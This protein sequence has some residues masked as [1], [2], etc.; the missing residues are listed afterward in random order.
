[1]V[2]VGSKIAL[3]PCICCLGD[4]TGGNHVQQIFSLTLNS[5]G[6]LMSGQ[7][8]VHISHSHTCQDTEKWSV[9]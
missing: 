6:G 8:G 3:L 5:R 4:G 7:A 9:H 2:S 1:M